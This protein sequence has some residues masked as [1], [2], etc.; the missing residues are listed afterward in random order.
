MII[1][2]IVLITLIIIGDVEVKAFID[3]IICSLIS[4]YVE[5]L[6]TTLHE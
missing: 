2:Y 1:P 6:Y 3:E 4:E 5:M